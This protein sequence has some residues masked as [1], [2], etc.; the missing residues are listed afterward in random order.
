MN[1]RVRAG[2]MVMV[3]VRLRVR[4]RV[5]DV[6]PDRVLVAGDEGG[7]QQLDKLILHVLDDVEV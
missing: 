7:A 2:V 1:A 5:R 6:L 3:R 4:V